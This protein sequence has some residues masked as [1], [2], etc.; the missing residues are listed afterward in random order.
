VAW[1]SRGGTRRYYT[2]SVRRDGR[3]VREYVGTGRV[4]EAAAAADRER[5][6]ARDAEG[7]ARRLAL[8]RLAEAD[9]QVTALCDAAE[10]AARACLL[11]A[12]YH[13][14]ARGSWRRR[15]E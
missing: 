1:E 6:A 5:R 11:M 2:R 3:V 15:R 12:G 4:G 14:H 10:T 7:E 8:G 13:R 9:A